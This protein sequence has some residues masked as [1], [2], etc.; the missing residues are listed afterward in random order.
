MILSLEALRWGV[1]QRGDE[2]NGR[3]WRRYWGYRR[4]RGYSGV[5]GAVFV[6]AFLTGTFKIMAIVYCMIGRA[7]IH[8]KLVG[9]M[10]FSLVLR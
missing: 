7:A 3:G 8:A 1:F 2:S 10:V 4:Y 5:I 6:N 9:D